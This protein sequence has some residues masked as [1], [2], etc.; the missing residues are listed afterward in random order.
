MLK[1]RC[2]TFTLQKNEDFHLPL[3]LGYYGQYFEPQD[4][5]VLDHQSNDEATLSTLADF[6][7]TGGNVKTV[8]HELSFDHAWLLDTVHWMQRKLLDRYEYVLFTDCDEWVIPAEGSLGEFIANA[9]KNTYRC[10]GYEVVEDK[11]RRWPLFDKTLLSRNELRWINGYHETTLPYPNMVINGD[12][13]LYHLHRLNRQAALN[14]LNRWKT[15]QI[16]PVAQQAKMGWQNYALSDEEFDAWFSG[17]NERYRDEPM[18]TPEPWDERLVV[19][20]R[21][22]GV[23]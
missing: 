23:V 8:E 13:F 12:L 1:R 22:T 7:N 14:K 19:E 15:Q 18:G 10:K 9:E 4:M 21:K 16:D 6:A 17:D 11:Q 5:Y 20:L 2:A 3:W